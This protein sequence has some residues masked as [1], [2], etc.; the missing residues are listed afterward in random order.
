MSE[1]E[2]PAPFVPVL[3]AWLVLAAQLFSQLHAIE[4]LDH[5]DHDEH[6]EEVCQLCI[7]G[8]DLDNGGHNT[9]TFAYALSRAAQLT[10]THRANSIPN[11]VAPYQSRAPPLLSSIA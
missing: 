3:L 10:Y 5:A 4:H 6:S 2:R 8:A 7:L 1:P 9:V 11:P